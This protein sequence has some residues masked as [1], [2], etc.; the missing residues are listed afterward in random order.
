MSQYLIAIISVAPTLSGRDRQIND[1]PDY[2]RNYID[3]FDLL[4][5]I[6]YSIGHILTAIKYYKL[7]NK[8]KI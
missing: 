4:P 8:I 1:I 3:V 5:F 6:E 7:L 2:I